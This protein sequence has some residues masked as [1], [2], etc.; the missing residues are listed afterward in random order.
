MILIRI[1]QIDV[2]EWSPKDI[3]SPF[4]LGP[5]AYVGHCAGFTNGLLFKLASVI[6]PVSIHTTNL[7]VILAMYRSLLL[8]YPVLRKLFSFAVESLIY[9]S[10]ASAEY[11][12]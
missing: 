6:K 10:S 11:S 3:T 2:E 1:S 4:L 12:A 8:L 7:E 5:A 9:A